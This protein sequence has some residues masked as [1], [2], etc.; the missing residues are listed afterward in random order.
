MKMLKSLSEI[1]GVSGFC[2]PIR[3]F[4]LENINPSSYE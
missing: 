2:S 4:I 1:S 3:E